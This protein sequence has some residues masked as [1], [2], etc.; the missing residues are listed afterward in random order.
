[1]YYRLASRRDASSCWEW[2]SRMIAS[3]DIL[4]RV[5]WM[6]RSVPQDRLRVFFSSS[7]ACLDLML[8]REN[9]GLASNSIPVAHLLHGRWHTNQSISQ[10]EMKE[11]ESALRTNASVWMGETSTI[12]EQDLPE[13]WSSTPSDGRM[14]V[15]DRR[16]LEIEL[17]TPGDHDTLYTFSLPTFLP[18]TLAWL[19]LLARR[20]HEELQP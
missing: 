6:Y 10:F 13:K 16:R 11:F 2:E 15:L 5:L 8:D 19:K 7:V 14:D 1:V 20:H 12:R 17:G 3:L 18:Q 4:F 9:K